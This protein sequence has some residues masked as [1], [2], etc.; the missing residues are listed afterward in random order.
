MSDTGKTMVGAIG[1]Q[2]LTVKNAEQVRDFYVQVVGWRS[3][4]E[5]MGDYEDFHMIAPGS[6]KS[7]AGVCHARGMNADLPPQWLLYVFVEDIDRSV[8]KCLDLGGEVV[9]G[10]RTMGGGQ[11]AVIRDPA[12]AVLALFQQ[13]PEKSQ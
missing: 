13:T 4:P 9:T 7:V 12:G 2:D 11:F 5:P 3:A 1:W 10:P 6:G 8:L